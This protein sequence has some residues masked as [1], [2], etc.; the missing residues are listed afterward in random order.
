[1]DFDVD[2]REEIIRGWVISFLSL[3]AAHGNV[4]SVAVYF[5]YELASYWQGGLRMLTA[6]WV[7]NTCIPV[8][9]LHGARYL[10]C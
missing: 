4:I 3:V 2:D 6:A 7:L 9:V 1:M 8:S 10:L 5:N